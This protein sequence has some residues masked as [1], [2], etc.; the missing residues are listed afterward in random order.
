MGK[1]TLKEDAPVV[2]AEMVFCRVH[3]DLSSRRLACTRELFFFKFE[4][5]SVVKSEL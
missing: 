4:K 3:L 1:P 5:N 2:V